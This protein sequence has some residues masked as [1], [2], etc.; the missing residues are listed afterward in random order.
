MTHSPVS[1]M[2]RHKPNHSQ[3]ASAHSAAQADL[4][5]Y[6]RAALAAPRGLDVSQV[7]TKADGQPFSS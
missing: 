4:A 2:A 5:I 1:M 6:N 7:G 3:V